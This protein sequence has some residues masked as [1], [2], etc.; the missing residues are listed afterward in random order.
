MSRSVP[1]LLSLPNH[2]SNDLHV[3]VS[4]FPNN[5]YHC[6]ESIEEGERVLEKYLSEHPAKPAS[7][8]VQAKLKSPVTKPT[9]PS[10]VEH[11]IP[12]VAT[13]ESWWCCFAGAEPGVYMG[14]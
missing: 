4:G 14:L 7:P 3:L 10:P 1:L 6:C 8:L 12:D 9:S 2:Y 13:D 5:V 11:S